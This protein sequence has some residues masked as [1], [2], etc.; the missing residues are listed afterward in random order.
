MCN[1]VNRLNK[2]LAHVT[3]ILGKARKAQALYESEVMVE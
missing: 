1:E 2:A 3:T